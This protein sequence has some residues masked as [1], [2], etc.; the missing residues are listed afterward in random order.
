MTALRIGVGLAAI[1]AG[2][3]LYELVA[4]GQLDTMSAL[5]KGGLV[6]A[7]CVFGASLVM[8]I[9]ENYEREHRLAKRDSVAKALRELDATLE[10]RQQ[11]NGDQQDTGQQTPG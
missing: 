1:V 11:Q 4:N 3:P 10:H 6:A 8:R 9:V 5:S 7:G 2:P